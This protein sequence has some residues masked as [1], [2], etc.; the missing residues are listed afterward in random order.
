MVR[1]GLIILTICAA[2]LAFNM[3]VVTSWGFAFFAGYLYATGPSTRKNGYIQMGLSVVESA[4]IGGWDIWD[5]CYTES[6]SYVSG[7]DCAWSVVANTAGIGLSTV[8]AYTAFT[9]RGIPD[10]ISIDEH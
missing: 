4:T 1:R 8:T 5:H 10:W 3:K 7:G 2:V 9:K 6:G